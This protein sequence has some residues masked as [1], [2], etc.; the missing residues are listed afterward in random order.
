M[1]VGTWNVTSL[2]MARSLT[3]TDRE[4]AIYKLHLVGVQEIRWEKGDRVRE[5]DYNF[6]WKRK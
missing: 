5:R 1:R 2:Y 4:V 3:A 6:L